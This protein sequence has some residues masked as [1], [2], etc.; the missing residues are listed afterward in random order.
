MSLSKLT[1][2]TAAAGAIS[3]ATFDRLPSVAAINLHQ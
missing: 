2:F 1:K 3:L